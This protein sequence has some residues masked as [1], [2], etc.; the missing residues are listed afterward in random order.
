ML[1]QDLNRSGHLLL[2]YLVVLLL[3]G[4]GLHPLPRERAAEEVHDHVKQRPWPQKERK[5][6]ADVRLPRDVE[7]VDAGAGIRDVW[8]QHAES[9]QA[10]RGQGES[11]GIL[12]ALPERMLLN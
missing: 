3:L 5:P 1:A 6:P 9:R 7:N 12:C 11:C 2:H 8:Q 10:Y 4:H